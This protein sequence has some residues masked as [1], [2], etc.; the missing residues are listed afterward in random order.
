MA[1]YSIKDL[2][3]LTGIK[4]HTSRVWE[5]RYGLIQPARTDTNIRFYTDAELKMLFNIALLNKKGHKISKIAGL[6]ASQIEEQVATTL[7]E[8]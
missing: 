1:V 7:L 2:E 4:A 6:T 5:L 8:Y 3:K